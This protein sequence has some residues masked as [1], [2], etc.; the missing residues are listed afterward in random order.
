[1]EP[2]LPAWVARKCDWWAFLSEAIKGQELRAGFSGLRGKAGGVGSATADL[3]WP[4]PPSVIGRFEP[5]LSGQSVSMDEW[6][7]WSVNLT[8]GA[9]SI[10]FCAMSHPHPCRKTSGVAH[11]YIRLHS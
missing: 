9:G 4:L 5:T 1:M 8:F 11:L 2:D 10:S 7:E 6:L 3:G